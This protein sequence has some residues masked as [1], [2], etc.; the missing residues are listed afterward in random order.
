M[1]WILKKLSFYTRGK[2]R[3]ATMIIEDGQLLTLIPILLP[4]AY[5][6][7]LQVSVAYKFIFFKK[8]GRSK[9]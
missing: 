3:Q 2:L 1:I 4:F 8:L 6:Q 7:S 5:R 9:I